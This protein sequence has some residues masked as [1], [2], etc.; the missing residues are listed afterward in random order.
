MVA[1][2][3][4]STH[5]PNERDAQG[6]HRFEHWYRDNTVYFITARCRDRFPAFQNEDAKQIFWDRFTHYTAQYGFVPWVTSLMNNHYHTLGYLKMGEDLGPMMQRIHGSVAKLV[7]DLLPVRHVPF[8]RE[9]GKGDYFDG[10]I[11]D[12]DQCRRAYRYTLRQGV[13]A[14]LVRDPHEYPHTRNPIDLDR[15]VRR[16]WDLKAFLND[17][18]YP[19]YGGTTRGK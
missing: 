1:R 17:V 10:C 12:E 6:R 19:R 13:R 14:G 3:R 15:G 7:N 5:C 4:I 11:R 9:K 2:F 18:P 8:W 16:A